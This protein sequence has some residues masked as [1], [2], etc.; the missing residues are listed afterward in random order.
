[1]RR[2][3]PTWALVAALLGL[4]AVANAG[5]VTPET[6]AAVERAFL[7]GRIAD[8]ATLLAPVVAENGLPPPDPHAPTWTDR[9]LGWR[10]GRGLGGHGWA[11]RWSNRAH[12]LKAALIDE[13]AAQFPV[14]RALLAER[15]QRETQGIRG[16][17]EAGPLAALPD[18][19]GVIHWALERQRYLYRRVRDEDSPDPEVS[20]PAR[21]R[22]E[23]ARGLI[24]VAERGAWASLAVLVLLTVMAGVLVRPRPSGS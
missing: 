12:P 24:A 6:R 18:P 3:P 5:E 7:D 19:D 9:M 2:A 20:V 17:P 11:D 13:T 4:P 22:T 1:V 15:E 21:E 14:V 16:L 8:A 23:R 10:A